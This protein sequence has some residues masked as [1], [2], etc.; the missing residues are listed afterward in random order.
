MQFS[1]KISVMVLILLVIGMLFAA[2]A[3]ADIKL[4]W[5]QPDINDQF[6]GWEVYTADQAGGPYE[7]QTEIEYAG[8]ARPSYQWVITPDAFSGEVF[9]IV[10]ARNTA[11]MLSDPSN[12]VSY[13]F[14]SPAVPVSLEII[15][16]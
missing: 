4:N 14:S 15:I 11:G 5:D 13:V 9:F 2:N 8:E 12:E 3:A 6:W 7:K 16:E 10:K 1:N